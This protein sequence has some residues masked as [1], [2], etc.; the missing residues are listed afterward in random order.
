MDATEA[1]R[2][3]VTI[4]LNGEPHATSARVVADLLEALCVE[5]RFAV[6]RNGE[7][8]P[9]SRFAETPVHD[10]DRIEVVR[11]IGGG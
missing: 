8:V 2:R 10:G 9:R 6:E 1:G 11:A 3:A 5:G 7:L 4:T